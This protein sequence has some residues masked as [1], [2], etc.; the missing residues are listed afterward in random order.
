MPGPCAT[1]PPP[2][3]P[4]R[5]RR[6]WTAVALLAVLVL[7]ALLRWTWP[8]TVADLRPRPDALEYE[9]AARNLATGRGYLL[10]IADRAYPPRYPPG[11]S[12]LIAASMPLLGSERG[13]GIWVVLASA[14]AA[15]A[16]TFA[17]ARRVAGSSAGLVAALL[18]AI[19]PLHVMSSQFVMSDVPA[20]AMVAAIGYGVIVV[21]DGRPRALACFALG[22]LCGLAV[23]LRQPLALLAGAAWLA[24]GLLGQGTLGERARRLAIVA[25]GGVI[26]VAPLLWINWQ[27]FGSPLRSGYGYWSPGAGFHLDRAAA[28][29]RPGRP[30]NLAVY[31]T[32]LA[33]DGYFY[34]WTASPLL[35]LGSIAA[36]RLGGAARR[37]CALTWLVTLPFTAFLTVYALR[38]SRLLLPVLPLVVATMA[39]CCARAAPRWMRGGGL[40][41][42]A[43]TLIL[44]LGPRRD[45]L[46]LPVA[47]G[48]GDVAAL[49]R[50]ARLTERDAVVLAHTEPFGFAQLLRDRADRVWVP[51]R[52]EEHQLTI[53]LRDL[54]PVAHDGSGGAWLEPPIVAAI[55][56]EQLLTRVAGLC[57][58]GRPVYLSAQ[59]ADGVAFFGR[60]ERWLRERWPLTE[61][62]GSEPW[63]YRIECRAPR[64]GAPP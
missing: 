2:P 19:A 15:I 39:L 60:I 24:V 44:V 38:S 18:L 36:L 50:L 20:T 26:G 8:A 9:E 32:T 61:V 33:G 34:P 58:S 55:G 45:L 1:S 56:R 14:L 12:A 62:A 52:P 31:L 47:Q 48:A 7:A 28:S 46:A 41:L 13:V 6:V 40:A 59:R 37:L 64:D 17:L 21:L 35:A 25:A 3:E 23:A 51:V 27:L 22:V 43:L 53:G 11:M 5:E 42:V 54:Q 16:A 57:A 49:Q 29:P 4:A 30:S 10:W 63:V